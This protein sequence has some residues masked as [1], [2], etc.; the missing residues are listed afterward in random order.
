MARRIPGVIIPDSV[1]KLN[2]MD[3]DKNEIHRI[4]VYKNQLDDA[5][6]AIRKAGY[7]AREFLYNQQKFN[8]DEQERTQLK[9]TLENSRTA[10]H[11]TA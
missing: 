2:M 7:T 1:K 11:Q 6:K 8:E 3:K 4:V 10:M 9:A 5:I